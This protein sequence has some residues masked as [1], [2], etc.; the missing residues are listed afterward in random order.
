MRT[1]GRVLL[2]SL[3]GLSG[4]LAIAQL[5]PYG[6]DH[7][8]P[9]VRA[10]PPWDRLETR[11]LALR[12]CFDCHSNQTDWPWYSHVAPVSWLVQRHVDD[13]R[14]KLNFSEWPHGSG[15]ADEAVEVVLDGEM[16]PRSYTLAHPEAVL[17]QD[18]RRSLAAGLAATMQ[19]RPDHDNYANDD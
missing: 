6:R 5:V 9:P 12:A 8:N 2:A 7:S 11:A 1:F 4:L 19:Y 17:D 18:Q 13:G 15:E 10:E 3:L 14:R 16:P